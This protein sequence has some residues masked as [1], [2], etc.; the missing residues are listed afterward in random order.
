MPSWVIRRARGLW[1]IGMATIV[2]WAVPALLWSQSISLSQQDHST[3][4]Q[5]FAGIDAS[6][7]R[8]ADDLLV[9]G[10]PQMKATTRQTQ[11]GAPN[12]NFP[13][14]FDQQLRSRNSGGLVAAAA[15]L[16]LLRPAI[17]P[18]LQQSGVPV[19]L[20]GVT[21]VESGA[22]ATALSP[23]GARGLWQLMPGTA[24]RY[25]LR[26]DDI[27]DD[28]LD[29][30]KSTR[31]AARYLS[32][33]HLQFGSWTLALAA[34]NSGEQNVQRA[35]SRSRS[36]EFAVLSSTGLLP[37]ETRNYVPRVLAAI[38]SLKQPS[39]L[40][41]YHGAASTTIVFAASNH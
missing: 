7:V 16:D 32:D 14:H 2:I 35:I 26:V 30:E 6:L 21:M 4:E 9:H 13:I 37:L 25:G 24:R 29:L 33:L 41:D 39:T 11:D 27:E 10:V 40:V 36:M 19:E 8:A 18:I 34:Y 15:R 23:K 31:A 12:A 20:A 17:E 5:P 38:Q 28:R 3:T 22:L 1:P